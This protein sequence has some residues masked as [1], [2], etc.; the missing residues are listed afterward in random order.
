MGRER[1][2]REG[3]AQAPSNNEGGWLMRASRE[4]GV[5]ARVSCE[6]GE[7]AGATVSPPMHEPADPTLESPS[8]PHAPST[9]RPHFSTS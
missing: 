1:E 2:A 4:R 5:T 6:R 3:A 7:R 9:C 8:P